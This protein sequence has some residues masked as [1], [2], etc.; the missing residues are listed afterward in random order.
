LYDLYAD[1][2][3]RQFVVFAVELLPPKG[4]RRIRNACHHEVIAAMYQTWQEN[5]DHAYYFW[6]EVYA[7][8]DAARQYVYEIRKLIREHR[9]RYPYGSLYEGCL[10]VWAKYQELRRSWARLDHLK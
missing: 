3:V 7:R 5:A 6:R 8:G 4:T 9:V 10:R 2:T 1:A